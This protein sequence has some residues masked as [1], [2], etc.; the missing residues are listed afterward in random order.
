MELPIAGRG[1]EVDEET[2]AFF[3]PEE[4]EDIRIRVD[5]VVFSDGSVWKAQP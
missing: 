1:E 3:M 5:E 2:T 4:T